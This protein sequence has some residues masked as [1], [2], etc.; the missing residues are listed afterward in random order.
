MSVALWIFVIIDE[1]FG[2]LYYLIN[3]IIISGILAHL[4]FYGYKR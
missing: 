4:H 1:Y 3:Y 2:K